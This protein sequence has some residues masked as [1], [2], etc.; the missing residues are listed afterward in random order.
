MS[1]AVLGMPRHFLLGGQNRGGAFL[2]VIFA[3]SIMSIM[4]LG[5]LNRSKVFVY[6]SNLKLDK[7]T[8][9]VSMDSGLADAI[10]SVESVMNSIRLDSTLAFHPDSE[11]ISESMSSIW[12]RYGGSTEEALEFLKHSIESRAY[13][14]DG[15]LDT[16]HAHAAGFD[17]LFPS[18]FTDPTPSD[19]LYFQ[20]KYAFY[21]RTPS[22]ETT[23]VSDEILFQYD[24]SIVIRA[25]GNVQYTRAQSS[26]SGVIE[27]AVKSAPFSSFGIFR[28]TSRNQNGD[29]LYFAGGNTSAQAQE[30]F[31]GPI[32][33]NDSFYFYGHPIFNG[34]VTSTAAEST[35]VQ[36]SSAN[37]D[38]CAVFND[39]KIGGAESISLPSELSNVIRLAAG[40][41]SSTAHLNT[42][43]LSD[44]EIVN[45]LIS[46]ADGSF[47]GDETSLPNGIYIP[48][49][50]SESPSVTGGIY[51]KGD[52]EVFLNVAQGEDDFHS[53]Y[54]SQIQESHRSCKFQKIAIDS[55]ETGVTSKDV[56]VGDAPCDVTY[57]F[58]SED[59]ET[60]PGIFNGRLNG[61]LHVEGGIDKL[62]GESRTRPAIA[63][64]FAFNISAT[65]DVRIYRD[66]QY[67]DI[68]Y[69]SIS[70]N[71]LVANA[72]GELNSSGL[73]PSSAD[74][75]P[76]ISSDSKTI[77][78]IISTHRNITLHSESPAN[79][80]LHAAL[81]AGNENAYNATTGLGCG[82]NTA[83][84]R[85]CGFGT[86]GW[87][88]RTG[89]G[90]FKF[91]GS[92][93]EFRNQSMGTSGTP[94]TGYQR[95]ISYDGRLRQD[96]MPPAFPISTDIQAYPQVKNLR[97]W[98]I[99]QA[100]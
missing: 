42:D 3:I 83:N 14:E 24:Y 34:P 45:F 48:V 19:D 72:W 94:P 57:V 8:A 68:E 85:G 38:C 63:Q 74:I 84:R 10:F 88:S 78:G 4:S 87:N 53:D 81:F 2:L 80:N 51:V 86:E 52:A 59:T 36:D 54:W 23:A 98:K 70:D 61:N 32:H 55:L 92:I 66:L 62:G 39:V 5:F 37:Y 17:Q 58:N 28:S 71:E 25:Y 82:V 46:H 6:L 100:N 9:E 15:I 41:P 31:N 12:S 26:Q 13:D 1:K 93:S 75:T 30:I 21:P 97:T 64:D 65:K 73:G 47:E 7:V 56:Y 50:N 90:Q 22:R 77:L 18:S 96:L 79:I 29:P 91:L 60:A 33:I 89:L 35:W 20:V 49:S 27:V 95:R 76:S 11:I 40:D 67:E 69:R 99:S 16:D 44:N 43:V